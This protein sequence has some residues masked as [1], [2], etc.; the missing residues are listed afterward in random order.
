MA[1]DF[2]IPFATT[3]DM[4]AIPDA[5]QPDGSVSMIQGFGFDYERDNTDPSY[6]PVPREGFNRLFHDITEALGAIQSSGFSDWSLSFAPY[7]INSVVRHQNQNWIS[8]VDNNGATPGGANSQWDALDWINYAIDAGA[9]NAYSVSY[10]PAI[11]SLY[12]GMV[13]RF[14]ASN[15][16]TGASTF[17]PAPGSIS[18]A[19]IVGGNH[20]ILQGGEIVQ[21]GDVWLQWNSS[22]GG[23]SWVLIESSGGALQVSPATQSKHA[24]S[25]AQGQA[26]FSP[27]VGVTRN[28]T[29]NVTVSAAAST[30]FVFDEAILGSVAGGQTYR[31]GAF[32]KLINLA[33][34]G[35]GGMDVG[36]A[37]TN[38]FVAVYVIYNPSTGT[39]ALLA[40]NAVPSRV[41]DVY[42]G[43]NMPAGY[44][45]S[46]LLSVWPT[47]GAGQFVVGY[48]DGRDI[49]TAS[50]GVLNATSAAASLT[51]LS[52]AGA[53]PKNAKQIHG[54]VTLNASSGTGAMAIFIAGDGTGTGTGR[55]NIGG[56][57]TT[58]VGANG[59]FTK[60]PVITPQTLYHMETLAGAPTGLAITIAISGYTI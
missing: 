51:S 1:R 12:D 48:Q 27:V 42:N 14:K 57:V 58:N 9:V 7:K 54:F 18:P 8:R 24:I 16:N 50:V 32:S 30:F 20:T 13:L 11:S 26:M 52:I 35:P 37:P 2:I 10:S 41:A 21:N 40:A 19:S 17:T 3:G 39:S 38:G 60:V 4:V 53:V 5:L 31:L 25:L 43:G 34:V 29:A 15:L 55:K 23:G 22:I 6:K 59:E 33:A 44:T 46:A 49:F 36:S 28:L 45:A 56:Y 47:N